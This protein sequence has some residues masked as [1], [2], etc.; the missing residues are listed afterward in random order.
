MKSFALLDELRTFVKYQT[1]TIFYV[2]LLATVQVREKM[3][4]NVVSEL[5]NKINKGNI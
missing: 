4:V 3:Y 2:Q 1:N 5:N